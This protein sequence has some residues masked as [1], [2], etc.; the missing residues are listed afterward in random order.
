MIWL[1]DEYVG[2]IPQK[3]VDEFLVMVTLEATPLQ[4]NLY[5]Y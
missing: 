1:P 5:P 2:N 3:R 4:L